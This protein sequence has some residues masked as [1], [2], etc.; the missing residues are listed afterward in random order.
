S[1]QCG[2]WIFAGPIAATQNFN[3]KAVAQVMKTRGLSMPVQYS[4]RVAD[5]MPVLPECPNGKG[6]AV[7]SLRTPDQ[8]RL[9]IEGH[10]FPATSLEV[11]LQN[12]GQR[13]RERHQSRFV[14]LGVV[15]P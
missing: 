6:T 1:G 15:N 12:V 2:L 4:S 8:R 9:R 11:L 5:L 3:C 7:P 14:E 10:S 13:W